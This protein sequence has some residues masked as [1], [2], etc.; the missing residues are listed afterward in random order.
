MEQHTDLLW[1]ALQNGNEAGAFAGEAIQPAAVDGP[2]LL[3]GLAIG[4]SAQLK[5]NEILTRLSSKI[6]SLVCI[7]N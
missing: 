5:E 6:A 7:M 2:N 3:N 1:K 4:L